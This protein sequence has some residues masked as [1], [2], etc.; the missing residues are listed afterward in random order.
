[1]QLPEVAETLRDTRGR[2]F[3]KL[4]KA[5]SSPRG[6][7]PVRTAPR[8]AERARLAPHTHPASPR[9]AAAARPHRFLSSRSRGGPRGGKCR[10]GGCGEARC[11]ALRSGTGPAGT[12]AADPAVFVALPVLLAERCS[13]ALPQVQSLAVL[14]QRGE[15]SVPLR[16]G[17]FLRASLA[18]GDNQRVLGYNPSGAAFHLHKG[19]TT[20]AISTPRLRMRS[21]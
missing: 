17:C 6:P 21:P 13:E 10:G 1:M 18:R 3:V 2:H 9:P 8:P 5:P 11:A 7:A 12:G 14:Y 4:W 19:E 16:R 15:T 20:T